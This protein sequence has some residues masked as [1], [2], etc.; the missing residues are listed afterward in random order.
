MAFLLRR[1]A[2][3]VYVLAG[4]SLIMFVV[5]RALPGDPALIYA[6]EQNV[7][8]ERL[9]R[10]RKELGL[11]RPLPVQYLIYVRHLLHGDFGRS[12]VTRE[13]I[14]DNLKM[15]YPATVELALA[16]IAIACG[17]GIPLGLA[18]AVFAGRW[19]DH[20]SRVL[21]LFMNAMPV[22]WLGLMAIVIFYAY[23]EWLPASGRVADA[24]GE[25]PR[26]TGFFTIDFLLAG[27]LAA[28]RSAM[29]HLVLPSVVL[30]AL[31]MGVLAR[32]TRASM[33]EVLE[34]QYV[35]AARAKGL[36]EWLV[37]GKHA[38]RNAG[39]PII[40]VVGLQFGNLVG[41]AVLTESIFSWPGVGRYAVRAIETTDFPAIMGFAITFAAL[42]ALI[43]LAV[44]V[45]YYALNPRVRA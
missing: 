43:N 10:A 34:Q 45:A 28:M 20:L 9:E 1:L 19:L 31:S 35:Q 30:S 37:L 40:T 44:D 6:G 23:L 14:I 18:S 25:P 32:I 24:F 13:P 5:S 12:L 39:I 21:A 2:Y 29:S 36:A 22:F 4:M 16:A 27:N 8:T 17:V 42:Y 33:L 15:Y 41:G 3:M 38:L 7:T 11:D 26:V